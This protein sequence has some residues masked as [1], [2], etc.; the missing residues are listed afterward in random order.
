MKKLLIAL[1]LMAL[2]VQGAGAWRPAGWVY[3][4]HPWAYDAA[5][6]DWHWFNTVDRQ[7][8]VNMSN[9]QWARLPNSAMASGWVFYNWAF[10]YA[11]S[12]G[13]WHW[14]NG[15]DRQWVVNMRTAAWSRYGV[16]TATAE[17][18]MEAQVHALI[19]QERQRVGRAPLAYDERIATVCRTHSQNMASG[20]VPFGHDGFNP[21]RINQI[22]AFL[23]STGWAENV[24]ANSFP[25]PVATAVSGWFGSPGH[26]ANIIDPTYNYTG[27]GVAQASD[28]MWYFTQIFVKSP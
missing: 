24:A 2:L 26:Y 18:L 6:G 9:G 8:V 7:W 23:P 5:S 10:A 16:Q 19:N 12:N 25:D 27:V 14:I 20:A 22:K 4:N 13:A 3:H 1:G 17:Q 28:G 15:A 11:Q 21:G